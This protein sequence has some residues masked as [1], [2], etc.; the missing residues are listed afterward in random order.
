M[1]TLAC[2]FAEAG[3]VLRAGPSGRTTNSRRFL[4]DAHR[5]LLCAGFPVQRTGPGGTDISP[6]WCLTSSRPGVGQG[7]PVDVRRSS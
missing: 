5:S 6:A 7:D 1:L 4:R 2:A 3:S